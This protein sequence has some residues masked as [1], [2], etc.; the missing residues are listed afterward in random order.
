MYHL[1]VKRTIVSFQVNSHSVMQVYGNWGLCSS[2][3]W[4]KIA[5]YR[6][7]WVMMAGAMIPGAIALLVS[8]NARLK[9]DYLAVATRCSEI[10]R[11]FIING[12][13]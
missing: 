5:T 10:I 12:G 13:S 6:F 9:G 3:Y 1:A 8:I 4:F 11:I 2:D 7:L